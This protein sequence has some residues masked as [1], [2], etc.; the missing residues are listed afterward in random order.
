MGVLIV[1]L[2][3]GLGLKSFSVSV[4]SPIFTGF[5][6]TFRIRH[7]LSTLKNPKIFLRLM[8]DF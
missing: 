6:Y 5:A 2:L 1:H 4:V 7:T 8:S 3:P